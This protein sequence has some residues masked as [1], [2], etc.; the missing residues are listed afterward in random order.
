MFDHIGITVK[1]LDESVRFYSAALEPLGLALGSK[2]EAGA[3]FGPMGTPALWLAVGASP[4]RTHIGF[5]SPTR[6]AV[7]AFYVRG[8]AAGARDNG[9]PGLRPD[10]GAAYYA[11]FLIDPDGNNVEAVC[12]TED[13]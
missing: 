7:D 11:A 9:A 6:S 3:G 1:D 12:M 8:L 2:D 13:V 5:S 4:S 10:Y